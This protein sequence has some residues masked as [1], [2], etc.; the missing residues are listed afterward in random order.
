MGERSM[1]TF[2]LFPTVEEQAK[3]HDYICDV[4]NVSAADSTVCPAACLH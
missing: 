1:E 2:V 3:Y 4:Y